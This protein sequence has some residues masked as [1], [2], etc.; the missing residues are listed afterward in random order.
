MGFD[1]S[2]GISA[3]TVFLQGL[4]SVFSP[5]VLPL[6]PLYIGYLAGGTAAVQPDGTIRYPR[7]R[8]LVNTL[9]SHLGLLSTWP[10]FLTAVAPSAL[11]LLLA[12]GALWWVERH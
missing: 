4:L 9:F 7:R 10:A 3:V 5:C 1:L 8:V 12:L 6:I 2:V 11:Y